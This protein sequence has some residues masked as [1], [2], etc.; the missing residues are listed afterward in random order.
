MPNRATMLK[1]ICAVTVAST[2]IA[3]ISS[4]DITALGIG[5]FC[6]VNAFMVLG[7]LVWA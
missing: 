7:A 1:T 4:G 6:V 3:M 2:G 5:S